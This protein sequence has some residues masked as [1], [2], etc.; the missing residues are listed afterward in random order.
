MAKGLSM[1]L[2]GEIADRGLDPQRLVEKFGVH[3]VSGPGGGD[4]LCIPFKRDGN[5]KNRKFRET[6]VPGQSGG[7]SWQDKQD[8]GAVRMLYNED[9]LR[10][11]SLKGQP[12]IITEGEPDLWAADLAGFQRVVGWPDGAPEFSIPVDADSPKY[13]PLEDAMALFSVDNLGGKG[14]PIII[15]ADG[16][17][18]G[19]VLLQ[20]LSIRLGRARCK[21][22]T[23]PMLPED[24]RAAF[25]RARCKDLGEVLE[26]YGPKGVQQTIDRASYVSAPGVY[27]LS[28]LPPKAH[29]PALDIGIPMLR[30]SFRMRLGDWSVVTG[31]PSHGKS[32]LVNDIC[33]RVVENYTTDEEP[34]VVTFASFE[35]DPQID[36]KRNLQWWLGEQHPAKQTT[37]ELEYGESWID[38]HFRFLMPDEDADV[39]LE[40]L[41]DAA[42]TS[43]IRDNSKVLVVDPWNEMDHVRM[44]GESVTDYTGRAIKAFRRFARKMGIHLMV[45]AHPTKMQQRPDGSFP[46]PTL[47]SISDSAHWFNKCDAGI[48]VH[49]FGDGKSLIWVQKTRYHDEIGVP[50][51]YDAL[52]NK[53]SRRF[54]IT[55]EHHRDE[56]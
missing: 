51:M 36:H 44:P 52:F 10:D 9:A 19:S 35:Q 50:K 6:M 4:F 39:S 40:W 22:L 45:V 42:A 15:A 34:F 3:S 5:V 1:R 49:N 37:H 27:R 53:T 8:K 21:F 33:C 30:N 14:V 54:E 23:Y 24:R 31:I 26:F 47:Y 25:G 29:P 56:M 13:K 48:I 2:T 16:D 11:A 43:V 12:V 41:L 46:I 38:R 55:G 17:D 7:K 28:E 20:D 32:T 18:A